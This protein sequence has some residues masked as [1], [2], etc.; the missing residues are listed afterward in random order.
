MKAT[1]AGYSAMTGSGAAV[2]GMFE[3]EQDANRARD[4]LHDVPWT[5]VVCSISPVS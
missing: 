4:M 2:F 1:G 3:T 5:A